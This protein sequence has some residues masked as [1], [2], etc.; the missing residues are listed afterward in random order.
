MQPELNAADNAYLEAVVNATQLLASHGV[1]VILD[2]H[3]DAL[4]TRNGWSDHDGAPTWL[5]NLTQPRHPYPYPWPYK[6]GSNPGDASEAVGQAFGD[7]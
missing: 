3:Q 7:I 1:Y 5:M 6:P 4:S 2:M